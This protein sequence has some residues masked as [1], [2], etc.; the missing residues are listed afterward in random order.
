MLVVEEEEF[1]VERGD[2]SCDCLGWCEL[3]RVRCVVSCGGGG[4]TCCRIAA[5]TRGREIEHNWRSCGTMARAILWYLL[6][7]DGAKI[8][9]RRKGKVVLVLRVRL[10]A[11]MSPTFILPSTAR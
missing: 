6:T 1:E 3:V 7:V 4:G 8:L 2:D 10:E 9:C 5:Q 11:A